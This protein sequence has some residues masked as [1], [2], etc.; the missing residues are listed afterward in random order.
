MAIRSIQLIMQSEW[1]TFLVI[2]ALKEITYNK[3]LKIKHMY[4]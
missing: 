3:T 4:I 1:K 2:I